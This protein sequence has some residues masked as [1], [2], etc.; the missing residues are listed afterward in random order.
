MVRISTLAEVKVLSL[1]TEIY[2]LKDS[3]SDVDKDAVLDSIAEL[4]TRLSSPQLLQATKGLRTVDGGVSEPLF[5][6]VGIAR[7]IRIDEDF[8]TTNVYAI[9]SP[10][11][12]SIVPNN[13]SVNVSIERLMLDTRD[14][15]H[16]LTSPSY[17]YSD[18]V[19]RNIGVD[20][21]LLYTFIFVHSKEGNDR[22]TDIYAVMPRTTQKT[23]SSG[24]VMI[25]T[26][27]SS[28]GFT[29]SYENAFYDT[30]NLI[31]ESIT[32]RVVPA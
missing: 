7:N 14:L 12:P 27:V 30:T 23:I 32:T 1:A 16:Y 2:K 9:G 10:T 15:N 26:N 11:R 31:D 25:A 17:W 29:Y 13:H 20:D 4:R 18:E 8:G 24:D 3:T 21:L 28:V 6:T 5:K 19:Q 22:R